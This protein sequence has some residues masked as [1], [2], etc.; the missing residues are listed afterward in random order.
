MKAISEPDPF[1]ENLRQLLRDRG[2]TQ[3]ELGKRMYVTQ[4]CIGEYINRK[5]GPTVATIR[6]LKEAIGCTWEDLLGE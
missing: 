3:T 1:G 4:A 5:G 6:R 2:I